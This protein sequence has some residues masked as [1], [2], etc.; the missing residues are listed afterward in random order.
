LRITPAGPG[1]FTFAGAAFAGVGEN[2]VI[3]AV[4]AR[5]G[6]TVYT[7]SFTAHR[8]A[9]SFETLNF[10]NIDVLAFRAV[11]VNL[12]SGGTGPFAAPFLIDNFTTGSGAQTAPEPSSL[13]LFG[14]GMAATG[15]V[16]FRRRR[17]KA[18]PD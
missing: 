18:S 5:D 3:T 15:L 11:P 4:G 6:N 14:I 7:E 16:A 9:F 1:T 8:N 17:L 2:L 10:Q 13:L 12:P